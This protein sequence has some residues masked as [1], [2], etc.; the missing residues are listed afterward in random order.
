MWTLEDVDT[1]RLTAAFEALVR[2]HILLRTFIDVDTWQHPVQIVL[3]PEFAADRLDLRI[4]RNAE[5]DTR[6]NLLSELL[7]RI[8]KRLGYS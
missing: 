7:R 4:I 2:H 1:G 3:D 6:T 5:C 8:E